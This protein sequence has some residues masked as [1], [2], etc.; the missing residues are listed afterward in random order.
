MLNADLC[1]ATPI[2]YLVGRVV[3]GTRVTV[4]GIYTIFQNKA[5]Y[6]RPAR[7]TRAAMSCRVG[8]PAIS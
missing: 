7:L 6:V 2:R 5:A 4:T 3:P 1:V 8:R